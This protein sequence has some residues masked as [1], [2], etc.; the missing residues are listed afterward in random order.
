[1]IYVTLGTQKF[2]FNRLLK[3]ID[4]AIDK[5][6]INE[7]VYA[8]IGHS[9]YKP[10]NYEYCKFMS[11]NEIDEVINKS[12]IIITHG[13]SGSIIQCLQKNKKVLAIARNSNYK[14][15]VD[16]HQFELVNKLAEEQMILK[17][18][19]EYEFLNIIDRIDFFEKRD[20]KKLLNNCEIIKNIIDDYLVDIDIK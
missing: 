15:H 19:T 9:T 11:K 8:Q 12:N 6:Y 10:R 14:E 13:G 2:Q 4:S 7:R 18:D 3:Y 1:M 16:N 5:G 20:I 17:A